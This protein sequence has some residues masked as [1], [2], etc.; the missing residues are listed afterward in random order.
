MAQ[1][2]W[3][4]LRGGRGRREDRQTTKA[5]PALWEM[6]SIS[7]FILRTM[8]SS[9]GILSRGEFL[10]DGHPR[11][12]NLLPHGHENGREAG[13]GRGRG[14]LQPLTLLEAVG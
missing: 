6:I 3:D 7:G 4:G 2:G 9:W 13:L 10:G 12:G 8:G 14:S 1:S 11:A 5:W